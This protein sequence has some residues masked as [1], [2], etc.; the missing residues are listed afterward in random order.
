VRIGRIVDL[1]HPVTT[2]MPVY[3]GDPA[4]RLTPAATIGNHGFNVLDVHMGSQSGTHVDA[5]FHFVEDGTRVDRMALGQFLAPAVIVDVRHIGERSAIMWDNVAPAGDRL[6][7]DRMVLL[8]TG[9]SRFW[10][11]DRY[12]DHPYLDADAAERL[13]AAGV[14]TVGIDALSTDAT[15]RDGDHPTGFATHHVLLGAD[16]AIIENLA[17]LDAVDWPDPFVSV[18]PL[19]L[20]HGDGAPV[21]AIAFQVVNE[22]GDFLT[23]D[24]SPSG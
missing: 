8:H 23:A 24:S 5:P 16:C 21:R 20:E 7:P 22:H 9:W 2:G 6:G 3:P 11:T 18:L 15:V 13:V 1:S 4:V 17:D 10:G 19:K 14:R 12:L